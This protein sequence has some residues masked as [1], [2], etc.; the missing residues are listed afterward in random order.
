MKIQHYS[1]QPIREKGGFSVHSHQE[2]LM[3]RNY[4]F[5]CPVQI[6]VFHNPA[7]LKLFP[8]NDYQ[9][10]GEIS[11]FLGRHDGRVVGNTAES[12]DSEI[13]RFAR[14]WLGCT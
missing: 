2:A 5:F 1:Q 4:A 14:N 13:K 9:E 12:N 7:L 8:G 6:V 10:E 11:W 3:S